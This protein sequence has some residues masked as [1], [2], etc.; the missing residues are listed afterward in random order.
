MRSI[1]LILCAS[2]CLVSCNTGRNTAV[3]KGRVEVKLKSPL[4]YTPTVN[5]EATFLTLPVEVDSNGNFQIEIP[6]REATFIYLGAV[7]EY[8]SRL[9]VEPGKEYEVIFVKEQEEVSS[10]VL[11]ESAPLQEYVASLPYRSTIR[12][13]CVT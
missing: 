9:L 3:I 2:L 6:L 11:D 10:E 13:K 1:V 4:T 5:G 7:L 8:S 12:K